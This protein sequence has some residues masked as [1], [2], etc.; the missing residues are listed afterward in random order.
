MLRDVTIHQLSKDLYTTQPLSL[1][2]Q[3]SSWHLQSP[4]Q[5]SVLNSW[6]VYQT[7]HLDSSTTS[8]IHLKR[9][10]WLKFS[11]CVLSAFKS[12]GLP[13]ASPLSVKRVSLSLQLPR[14]CLRIKLP[15]K[16]QLVLNY[17]PLQTMHKHIT[18]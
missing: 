1:Y 6:I 10:Y 8:H 9:T 16:H 18:L 11:L 7:P 17:S 5:R 12:T 2:L 14:N 3:K 13:V 15:F 4:L